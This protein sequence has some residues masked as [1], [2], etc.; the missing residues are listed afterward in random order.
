MSA[1]KDVLRNA[2]ELYINHLSKGRWFFVDITP[3]LWYL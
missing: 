2:H 1:I 3:V